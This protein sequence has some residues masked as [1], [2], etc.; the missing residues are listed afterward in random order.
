MC[1][2][3]FCKDSMVILLLLLPHGNSQTRISLCLLSAFGT[4]EGKEM[5]DLVFYFSKRYCSGTTG[6]AIRKGSR[7]ACFSLIG[8]QS[9]A[10]LI[11]WHF[12]NLSF[13]FHFDY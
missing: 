8:H 10:N 13:R 4:T 7:I 1:L 9:V 2:T 3:S 5:K 11:D 6:W 12:N